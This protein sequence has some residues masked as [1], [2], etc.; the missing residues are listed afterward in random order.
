MAESLNQLWNKLWNNWEIRLLVLS[1]LFL[2][3]FLFVFAGLRKHVVPI[4]MSKTLSCS[5]WAPWNIV[6]HWLLWLSYLSADFIAITA[7]GY[8]SQYDDHSNGRTGGSSTQNRTKHL[9]MFWA[10]FLLLHLG[11]QDTITA[12]SIE[13]N[14]L[15]KRHLL[16]L[17]SEVV[18]AIYVYCKSNPIKGGLWPAAIPMFIA[19]IVKY[20]ERTWS[21]QQAS[22]SGLWTSVISVPEPSPNHAMMMEEYAANRAAGLPSKIVVVGEKQK[23][24]MADEDK[25]NVGETN[26]NNGGDIT[27]ERYSIIVSQA[28]R[29]FQM[30]KGLFVD[31]ILSLENW[32]ESKKF[33]KNLKSKE[34]YKVTEIELLM[35]YEMLHSKADLLHTW[36]GC[37]FRVL[38]LVCSL[39]ALCIFTVHGKS[40]FGHIEIGVTYVLLVGAVGLDILSIFF[41]LGSM[42]TFA[43]LMQSATCRK[44]EKALFFLVK[45]LWPADSDLW[46]NQMGQYNLIDFALMDKPRSRSRLMKYIL[47][48]ENWDNYRYTTYVTIDKQ[49]K[50]LVLKELKDKMT[51]AVSEHRGQW[52]LLRQGYYNVLRWSVDDEFEKSILIWHVATDLLF[53]T[54]NR[55]HQSSQILPNP[56]LGQDISN[57]MLFLLIM[58]PFMLPAGIGKIRFQATC[59]EARN[60]FTSR[61]TAEDRNREREMILKISTEFDPSATKDGASMSVLFD[62][63][64]LAHLLQENFAHDTD[65]MWKLINAVWVE[66]LCFA[67][68]KCRGQF[69]AKQ[70]SQGSEFLTIVWLLMAQLGLGDQCKVEMNPIVKLVVAK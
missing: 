6:L 29:F 52:V 69:H 57:Y 2:Q 3:I 20:A 10:P 70:M 28:Y 27:D 35:M 38:T 33:F 64:R 1:S 53:N 61:R 8:L 25:Q 16:T 9:S 62:G 68:N 31:L 34:A 7:L 66:M 65:A 26:G 59:A 32:E 67:A 14:E 21:L 60:F 5:W 36:H 40:G 55:Q 44:Y 42:W 63:C 47:F 49:L 50:D 23:Q 43:M 45:I 22:M 18:F 11:G 37:A 48:N 41:M 56:K 4:R 17:I 51:M 54:D 13:D 12:L 19:G 15:W 24:S 46:S 39:T 58:R 30:F